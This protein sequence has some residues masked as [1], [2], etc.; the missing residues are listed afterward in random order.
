MKD[1]A[2]YVN[3]AE[4]LQSMMSNLDGFINELVTMLEMVDDRCIS[5]GQPRTEKEWNEIT[6]SFYTFQFALYW[7][8]SLVRAVCDEVTRREM[9][10]IAA[11][12]AK[13]AE[14]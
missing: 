12:R 8:R 1:I 6:G 9:E 4:G 10:Q 2:Q 5:Q 3:A 14:G 11:E 13:A 7:Y